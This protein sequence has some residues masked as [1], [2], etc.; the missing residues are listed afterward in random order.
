MFELFSYIGKLAQQNKSSGSK[1]KLEE[2][3]EPLKNIQSVEDLYTSLRNGE[4]LGINGELTI[5]LI[6]L[7]EKSL[8]YKTKENNLVNRIKILEKEINEKNSKLTTLVEFSSSNDK[9]DEIEKELQLKIQQLEQ[10]GENRRGELEAQYKKRESEAKEKA[11]KLQYE[12]EKRDEDINQLKTEIDQLKRTNQSLGNKVQEPSKDEAFNADYYIKMIK[13]I[14]DNYLIK[15]QEAEESN[16]K[17]DQEVKSR[18]PHFINI[19][20]L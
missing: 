7:I 13:Q 1:S 3:D 15:H 4:N 12:L 17:K 2:K 5:G 19:I 9:G 20:R 18:F 10:E 14:E 16:H 11:R 6:N 8:E